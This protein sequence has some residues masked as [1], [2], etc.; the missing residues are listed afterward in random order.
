M[1]PRLFAFA[2]PLTFA[3]AACAPP[4][5]EL[6]ADGKAAY[7][8][9]DYRTAQLNLGAGL[10]Q[11]PDNPAMQELLTRALLKLGNGEGA[12]ARLQAMD[13][14]LRSS[15]RIRVLQ[16]EADVLRTR[17]DRAIEAVEGLENSAAD[18]VRALAYIGKGDLVRAL[19]SL[20]AGTAREP[21]DADLLAAFARFEFERGRWKESEA[22]AKRALETVPRTIEAM[23]VEADLKSRRN[24]I[25][26]ALAAYR[27]ILALQEDNFNAGLGEARALADMGEEKAALERA[28]ALRKAAP[29]SAAVAAVSATLS[30]ARGD[31][32][33]VRSGLQPFEAGLKDE[34][35][36]AILYAEAL[37]AL[38]LPAQGVATLAPHF[39]HQPGWR[40]LR[41]LYARA[42]FESGDAKA[43]LEA[44]EPLV[45]RPDA[46]PEEL[47]LGARITSELGD[48]RKAE[49]VKRAQKP[50][51]QWVGGVLAKADRALRNRQ[52][53]EAEA[54]YRSIIETLGTANALT[55][56]NLAYAQGELG[57]TSE[58]LENALK[59]VRL[60]PDNPSILDTTGVLLVRSGQR[61]RGIE[62]LE[63]AARLAPDNV[64]IKHRLNEFKAN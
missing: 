11:E 46:T 30:A 47:K 24:Q 10:D 5:S 31:W 56:N 29:K 20:E 7:E 21:A 6:F 38:D 51:P 52:W 23:L 57:K 3:L 55:L 50:S 26:E 44:L 17:F 59:A 48:G 22:L 42:Q 62:M 19:G 49:F 39:K 14:G 63:K 12:A 33:A 58:A 27:E 15:D 61:A 9:L 18:R 43:A 32:E 45:A 28:Q 25:P 2:V 40:K 8:N 60:E 36:A 37:V 1:N 41:T 16:G 64:S 4:A 34:P 53:G 54:A 35:E 13:A